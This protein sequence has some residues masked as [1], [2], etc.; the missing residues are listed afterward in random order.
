MEYWRI[1]AELNYNWDNQWEKR[2]LNEI[3]RHL[4][5]REY[6]TIN[7][8]RDRVVEFP[9]KQKY[10]LRKLRIA[11][12]KVISIIIQN[13]SNWKSSDSSRFPQ[14]V[15]LIVDYFKINKS[16]WFFLE[17]LNSNEDNEISKGYRR[18]SPLSIS[19]QIK[20]WNKSEKPK[21]VDVV[22]IG[23]F[24]LA[25]IYKGNKEKFNSI[26]DFWI[27]CLFWIDRGEFEEKEFS[28]CLSK[29]YFDAY[30]GSCIPIRSKNE[31][32]DKVLKYVTQKNINWNHETLIIGILMRKNWNDRIH[33]MEFENEYVLHNWHTTL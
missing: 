7:F 6:R 31:E 20:S 30:C 10:T 26:L 29:G 1:N 9:K 17:I 24:D 3:R 33:L 14:I 19:R 32:F 16:N 22:S 13:D 11:N 8:E 21:K 25:D 18:I 12:E 4:S 27:S 2:I 23:N 5:N 28:Y 15:M